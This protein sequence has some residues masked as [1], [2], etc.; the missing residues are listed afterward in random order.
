MGVLKGGD[1]NVFQYWLWLMIT[2]KPELLKIDLP[3]R[4]STIEVRLK[5]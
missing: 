1:K 5:L 4:G 2:L 3:D